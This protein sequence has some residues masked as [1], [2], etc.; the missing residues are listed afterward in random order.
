MVSESSP[1]F[2]AMP[3]SFYL[4][5]ADADAATARALTFGAT[6]TMA[7]ADMP[8]GDRQSGV[9][10]A[11]GNLWWLSQRTVQEPYRD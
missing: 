2:P 3:A 11:H 10:D 9:R 4:Y 6:L 1:A 5:V 8:Y 7:V